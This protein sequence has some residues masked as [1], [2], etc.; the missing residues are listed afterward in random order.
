VDPSNI[1]YHYHGSPQKF[2]N[3]EDGDWDLTNEKFDPIQKYDRSLAKKIESEGYRSQ[4]DL[5]SENPN[6]TWKE[7]ND[8]IHPYLN[9]IAVNIGRH[10]QMGKKSSG[11]HR[12][13]VAKELELDKVPVVVRA[14]HREWQ[15]IRD[16]VR[17][18][19]S[20]SDLSENIT[21]HLNHPDLQE[22]ALVNH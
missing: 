10:G 18:A 14:R 19:G 13:S 17:T 12:L 11:G 8:A 15:N 20:N 21:R 9:E 3:V 2:G 16:K 7:N 6:Q 4:R 5:F 1:E 22:L